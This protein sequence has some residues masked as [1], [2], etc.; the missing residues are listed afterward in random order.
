MTVPVMTALAITELV[1]KAQE[2][3]EQE[4]K[5]KAKTALEKMAKERRFRLRHLLPFPKRAIY[6]EERQISPKKIG[7]S[8]RDAKA[9][10]ILN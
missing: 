7:P 10:Q 8:R 5:A 6:K 3:K 2:M 4:K 9:L 1:M